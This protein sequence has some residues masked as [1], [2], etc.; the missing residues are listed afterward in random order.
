MQI[1]LFMICV[2]SFVGVFCVLVFL[3]VA[4]QLI[5]YIFPEK[6]IE[7]GSDDAVLYAA[8]TSAYARMYPG[9]RVSKIE[10]IK[11]HK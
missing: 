11:N 2:S 4:M 10:E 1:N 3:A 6:K 8:I 7:T 5:M 9:T